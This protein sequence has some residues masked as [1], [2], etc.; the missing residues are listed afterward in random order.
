MTLGER[1]EKA[2]LGERIEETRRKSDA[3]AALLADPQPGVASWAAMVGQT[4]DELAEHA[5]SFARQ[6]KDVAAPAVPPW[7][8]AA[9]EAE[10]SQILRIVRGLEPGSPQEDRYIEVLMTCQTLLNRALR[11][12]E[13]AP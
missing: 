13:V 4:L 7:F 3:L 8:V 1:I 11:G 9:I 12:P 6:V 10:R 5:P 2:K